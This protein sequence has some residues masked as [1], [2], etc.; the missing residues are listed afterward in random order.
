MAKETW[1][2]ECSRFGREYKLAPRTDVEKR[3]LSLCVYNYHVCLIKKEK[4]VSVIGFDTKKLL[5]MQTMQGC[6]PIFFFYSYWLGCMPFFIKHSQLNQHNLKSQFFRCSLS[7]YILWL[8]VFGN[9]RSGIQHYW[10][11]YL[12]INKQCPSVNTLQIW[13][14]MWRKQNKN[15]FSEPRFEPRSVGW[16]AGALTNSAMPPLMTSFLACPY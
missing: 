1:P 2:I 14:Q 7:T 16:M 13:I 8:R 6:H 5:N 4:R 3:I 15:F 9:M 11:I 10:T 12:Y